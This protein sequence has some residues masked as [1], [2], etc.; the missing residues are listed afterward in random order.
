[1]S[2]ES[3]P[4][5]TVE[6]VYLV[7]RER[8]IDGVYPP[9]MRL[10]QGGLA[11]ELEISRTPLREA[12]HRLEADGLVVAEANR[13][14]QVAPTSVEQVE[15][16]YALRL[17]VEPPTTAGIV[18]LLTDQDLDRMAADLAAMESA[19]HR[20][21]DFQEVH[22]RFHQTAVARYPR[23]LAELTD[24][25][26]LKIFRHQRLYLSHPEVPEHFTSVDRMFLD[27]VRARDPELAR[28][29]LE[30]H[31]IDAGLG[32]VL[33]AEPDHGFDALL[34]AARGLGIE[35]ET[36][37]KGRIR[38]RPAAISWSRPGS[39]DSLALETSNLRHP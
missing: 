37:E 12:L 29:V 10:S 5:N 15:Q 2:G 33:D 27:A 32:L 39:R 6:G 22:L 16:Y 14:M 20:I 28:Q 13:G 31:L 21:R 11:A 4:G 25:L 9:G 7:L 24:S 30:F 18:A 26:A 38:Q 17:L 36:D 23:A 35:I 1:M 3:R 8:I 19:H 34:I